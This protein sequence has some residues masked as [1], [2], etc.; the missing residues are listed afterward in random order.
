MTIIMS[1]PNESN[2]TIIQ[3]GQ[4]YGNTSWTA[5]YKLL[6]S[7]QPDTEHN[8]TAVYHNPLTSNIAWFTLP[9]TTRYTTSTLVCQVDSKVN[10]IHK[11]VS[12]TTINSNGTQ[13]C[14]RIITPRNKLLFITAI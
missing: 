4:Q 2:F 7:P 14:S 1:E 8:C 11:K 6:E 10:Q 12:E 9:C 3:M 5:I 13:L